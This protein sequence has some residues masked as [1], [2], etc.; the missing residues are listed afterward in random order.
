MLDLADRLVKKGISAIFIAGAYHLWPSLTTQENRA[1]GD[2][3]R[4]EILRKSQNNNYAILLKDFAYK[5]S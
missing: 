3:T 2:E 1:F 5:R 4:E